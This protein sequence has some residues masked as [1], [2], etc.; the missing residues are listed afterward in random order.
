VAEG[1][2]GVTPAGLSDSADDET[3]P[4]SR[5]EKIAFA[6]ERSAEGWSNGRIARELGVTPPAVW[7]WLNPEKARAAARRDNAKRSA[8]KRVWERSEAGRGRCPSCGGLKGTA[9]KHR[10]MVC[11]KCEL[12]MR[13]QRHAGRDELIVQWW[14]EGA[15]LDEIAERLGWTRSHLGV[16]I[17]RLRARG[18]DLPYRYQL[19]VPRFPERVAA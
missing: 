18:L 7:K 15:S 4:M 11:L 1:A 13:A 6:R 8:A 5:D 16:E 12:A 2:A 10:H 19:S 17:H 14:H 9:S 3:G